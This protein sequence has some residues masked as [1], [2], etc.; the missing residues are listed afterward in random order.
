MHARPP[1][2]STLAAIAALAWLGGADPAH[3]Q[4][5]PAPAA[6]HPI[7]PSLQL[8][9]QDTLARLGVLARRPGPVGAEARKAL[10]LV[11]RHFARE[12]EY[13]LP[14]LT[15]LPYLADGKVTPDM[16]WAIAMADRVRADREEIF[17]EHT[18]ITDAFNAI[19]AAARRAHDQEAAEFAEAGVGDSLNDLELIEP[20]VLVIGE[21]L[22]EKL[23]SSK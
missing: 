21:F 14:P 6:Q 23:G 18:Q 8:E 11:K 13:I 15:L 22:R 9:H 2:L 16:S 5:G 12:D 3:A 19:A 7:P 4:T 20:G 17:Q 10:P 1:M